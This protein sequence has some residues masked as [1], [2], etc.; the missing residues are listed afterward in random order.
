MQALRF[1]FS[2]F[3]SLRPQPFAVAAIAVYVAGVAS[4]WL[5]MS[6]VIMRGGLWPFAVA[7]GVLIWVWFVLHTKRLRD[8]DRPIG[9]AVGASLLYALSVVLLLLIVAAAF[10]DTAAGG[11]ADA[12]ATSALGLLL[13]LS[14]FAVLLGS[15]QYDL[16]WIIEMILIVMAFMPV[17][18]AVGV[19]LWAATRPSAQKPVA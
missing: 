14:I 9:L 7:Q 11:A 8:A 17:I 12:N 16:A 2:P 4:Q 19:T 15:P 3:G 1:F 6:D 13:L 5:T 10:F 18:L